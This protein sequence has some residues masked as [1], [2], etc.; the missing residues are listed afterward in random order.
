MS[1]PQ[2]I[3]T[4]DFLNAIFSDLSDYENVVC[5]ISISPSPGFPVSQE[6]AV[7]KLKRTKPNAFF[8]MATATLND[9]GELR[10]R[11]KQFHA[12]YCIVLDD[13]GGKVPL[14]DLPENLREEMSWS[15]ET[16]P[17]NYQFG[18]ILDEPIRDVE[19]AR[20]FT[21]LV[22]QSG[23][24]D[25]GGGLANKLVRMPGGYN[26][27]PK[28]HDKEGRS[29]QTRLDQ[30]MPDNR[31][32]AQE[33]LEAVGSAVSW[34][35][36]VADAKA[37]IRNDPYRGEGAT[38]Y[39]KAV[40]YSMAGVVDEVLEW[41]AKRGDVVT[42]GGECW[43]I[44]CPWH[45]SH[46]DDAGAKHG[47]RDSLAGYWPLGVG[48]R[49]DSRGFNCLHDS[50]SDQNTRSFLE[51]V[52]NRGGPSAPI[53]DPLAAE[54]T[55]WAFE[56]QGSSWV[57]MKHDVSPIPD[58]GF[59]TFMSEKLSIPRQ[60]PAGTMG[61]ARVPKYNLL[62]DHPGLVRF[63]GT[64]YEPGAGNV[65][66]AGGAL[67][68][69][70]CRLPYYSAGDAGEGCAAVLEFF[71]YLLPERDGED[72]EWFMDHLAMKTQDLLYRGNAVYMSTPV[73]GTGRG[74]MSKILRMLFG[75][76]NVGAPSMN[77]LLTGIRGG[78]NANL[79]KLVIVIP[80]AAEAAP[81]G[82]AISHGQF[83]VLK[84]FCDPFP[85]LMDY[86]AKH[87]AKWSEL[88]YALTIICSNTDE[89]VR[90][91]AGDRRFRW[92]R[93]T[94]HKRGAAYFTKLHDML[95]A[96]GWQESFWRFLVARDVSGFVPGEAA[97][98]GD[99]AQLEQLLSAMTPLS[100]A[101]YFALQYC[102]EMCGG[103]V[104]TK[105]LAR[106]LSGLPHAH[107]FEQMMGSEWQDIARKEINNG[108]AYFTK[109]K[110]RQ[111]AW[112]G[113][114]NVAFR[115]T[116]SLAGLGVCHLVSKHSIVL[117]RDKW[118]VNGGGGL[119]AYVSAKLEEHDL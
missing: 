118:K 29:P 28:Y 10:N 17:G 108:S 19:V 119:V 53:L 8:S 111:K 2:D 63:M 49:P 26:T 7:K 12:Q 71:Q 89:A 45:G 35:D 93:N 6:V 61:W 74:T 112:Y 15:I 62:L 40:E 46:N 77:E 3:T 24:G 84:Q 31:W 30:W 66:E 34:G 67:S 60:T 114:K 39:R 103:V 104:Y 106:E 25:S 20:A 4:N 54:V 116:V 97:D 14:E 37:A 72:Y 98:D 56:A 107:T 21:K 102:D 22:F 48:D 85:V 73:H 1:E 94:V 90:R 115:H 101:V 99:E 44:V 96:G 32:T 80:E 16:S 110:V 92:M 91:E 109:G 100:Q 81:K 78:F 13:I 38:A 27:K 65:V 50:C 57:D 76:A 36:L 68:I 88:N 64:V 18:Y 83:E 9:E 82:Y 23:C 5:C 79:R 70:Q 41:M 117:A 42:E 52:V 47:D 75:E 51:E 95:D 33:M 113:G 105:E 69:N 59:K 58:K 55:R 86:N 11:L 87:G 43:D